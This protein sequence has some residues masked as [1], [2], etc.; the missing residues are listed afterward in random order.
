MTSWTACGPE[1]LV[2]VSA[3]TVASAARTGSLLMVRLDRLV[4]VLGGYGVRLCCCPVSRSAELRGVVL[5]DA[6]DDR[7]E[8][9]DVYLAVGAESV[10]AA[11]RAA[12]SVR[13][14]V[15]L[16]RGGEE[17]LADAV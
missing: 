10:A 3:S 8:V 16:V 12:V 5:R 15:V 7:A 2:M 9:G 13:A 6:T 17:L 14:V 11:V 1:L 4:N